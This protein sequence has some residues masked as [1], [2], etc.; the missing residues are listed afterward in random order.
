MVLEVKKLAAG[1]EWWN[2][3]IGVDLNTVFET[4]PSVEV[5][6]KGCRT[7][8]AILRWLLQVPMSCVGDQRRDVDGKEDRRR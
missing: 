2:D 1:L 8:N 7:V 3:R 4:N 6:L 5:S